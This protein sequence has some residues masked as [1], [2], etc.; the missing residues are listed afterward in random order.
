[1]SDRR[2]LPRAG[3]SEHTLS[4]LALVL[5]HEEVFKQVAEELQRNVLEGKGRAVEELEEVEVVVQVAERCGVGVAEGGIASV[6]DALEVFGGDL[7]GGD[8]EREDLVG[9]VGKGEVLPVLPVGDLGDV[10]GDEE[11]A[12]AGETL[13]NDLLEGELEMRSALCRQWLQEL[14]AMACRSNWFKRRGYNIHRCPRRGCS[15]SAAT[16]CGWC[17]RRCR[18]GR[19]WWYRWWP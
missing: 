4:S 17:R 2:S 19:W 7:G 18:S 14:R 9:E 5:A 10:L 13:E 1:M 12:V 3:S 8:V 16:G 11:T 15:G 6:D